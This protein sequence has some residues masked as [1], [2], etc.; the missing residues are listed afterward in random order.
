MWGK[1]WYTAIEAFDE[2]SGSRTATIEL[3]TAPAS[4][5]NNTIMKLILSLRKG[6][7]IEGESLRPDVKSENEVRSAVT[8]ILQYVG[9][10]D[11]Y[12][13]DRVYWDEELYRNTA[14]VVCT[15]KIGDA[16][17]TF[18]NGSS[19]LTETEET[20][21]YAP[22]V[23]Q[24]SIAIRFF[25]EGDTQFIWESPKRILE[26]ENENA[27]LL[28]FEEIK[29]K[30]R[31]AFAYIASPSGS[32]E[33]VLYY[34]IVVSDIRLGY[35]TVNRAGGGYS[36]IPVWDFFG[37]YYK[38]F[39]SQDSTSLILDENGEHK[40]SSHD[41]TVSMLTLNAIDGSIIDRSAG[42]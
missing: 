16:H 9:L 37:Y 11:E 36:T 13:I 14:F 42:Y 26:L 31:K 25:P 15:R 30:A 38:G 5:K 32:V 17:E 28:S 1:D 2:E 12:T 22:S 4:E 40:Y 27:S 7:V 6:F 19:S 34:R 24:D 10:D 3:N 21:T 29:E 35:M 8:R 39:A 20:L 33:D 41:G 23:S 18:V